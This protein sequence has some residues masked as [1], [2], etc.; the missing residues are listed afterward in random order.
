VN[1]YREQRLN[2]FTEGNILHENPQSGANQ[3]FA[4]TRDFVDWRKF[5]QQLLSTVTA[6]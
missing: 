2:V 3:C 5:F 1:K 4:N 6:Q